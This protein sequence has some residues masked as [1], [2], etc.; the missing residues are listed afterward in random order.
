M[1]SYF[2][3]IVTNKNNTTFYIGMTNDL[4]RRMYEHKSNALPG[5]T[6]KYKL[7]KIVYFEEFTNPMDAIR[8]EKQLKNWHREWKINLIKDVNPEFK[9]LDAEMNSA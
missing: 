7:K 5:F 4:G 8:R 1:K 3:Y 9:D 6:S 2:I